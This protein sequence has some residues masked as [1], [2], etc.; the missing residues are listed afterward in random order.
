MR[1][2]SRPPSHITVLL[3][4]DFVRCCSVHLQTPV[5]QKPPYSSST[6][7]C[8][9]LLYHSFF[10]FFTLVFNSGSF[11]NF[12]VKSSLLLSSATRINRRFTLSATFWTSRGHRCR[13]FSPPVRAFIFIAHIRFSIPTAR[14][15]SSKFNVANS[16]SP[17]F[18]Y[19]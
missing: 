18:R 17:A 15:L 1:S 8:T 9:I 14:R 11:S 12:H 6:V 5:S 7:S 10:F 16:R 4:P 3:T 13:P 2:S 19:E